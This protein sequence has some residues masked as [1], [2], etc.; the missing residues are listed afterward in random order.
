M[1]ETIRTL[2]P[3]G[4]G[5]EH[6][7]SAARPTASVLTVGTELVEG[8]R[9]D[10]NTREVAFALASAGYRVVEAV[11][12]GDDV[13]AIAA[14]LARLCVRD[15]LVIATGGLGPTHDDVTRE[16]AAR[17]LEVPLTQD[18][19]LVDR[20]RAAGRWHRDPRAIEQ[21]LRQADVLEGAIVLDAVTGTAPGQV[22]ATP[23]GR[24][25]LLPGPPTEMRP[26]LERVANELAPGPGRPAHREIGCVGITESDAQVRA[27]A[28]LADA[29]G[30]DLTV[31]A[32]PGDVRIIL[33]D[34]GAGE[35]ALEAA[36]D[37]ASEALG[38]YVYARDES[39][40]PEAILA[41][42]RERGWHVALAESCTGGMI[43]V[44]LTAVAG[45][46]DVF[47]GGVVSY[48]NAAKIDLLGVEPA[49]L[50]EH[51]AVSRLTA[52]EMAAGALRRFGADVAV[53][54]TGIA[55]P[56][57]DTAEKPVGLVWFGVASQ[58]QAREIVR[59]YSGDRAGIRIRAT[60]TALDL[61]RREVNGLSLA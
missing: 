47:R 52:A 37:A 12:V 46:S 57:G 17:A 33:F 55:G 28:A 53:S 31:L 60:T 49:T 24:L 34:G 14:A 7:D 5:S 41:A 2:M 19:A 51:G 56:S 36:A 9:V 22:I 10:T 25:A 32:S 18:P 54:V 38:E 23:G 50:E 59:T 48:A 39:S 61:L 40:L 43:S 35:P 8:L 42:Y 1:D 29:R 15:S 6:V 27:S 45:S 44:A 21:L 4:T 30:V 3:T 13:D 20:L 11:S 58:A 26:M 16:A